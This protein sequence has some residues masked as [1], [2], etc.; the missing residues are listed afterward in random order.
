MAATMQDNLPGQLTILKSQLQEL[1]I[2]FGEILMPVIRSI[3][4]KIQEFTDKLNGMDEGTKKNIVRIAAL[5]A[6]IGPLLII[7]GTTIDREKQQHG[8]CLHWT[9]LR[10]LAIAGD[11]LRSGRKAVRLERTLECV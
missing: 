5:V 11:L 8:Q 10:L 1:A 4:T 2:S 6:A 9:F 7:I 3:V